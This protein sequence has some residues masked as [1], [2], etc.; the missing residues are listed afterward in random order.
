MEIPDRQAEIVA[1]E[2]DELSY[3][4]RLATLDRQLEALVELREATARAHR[5]AQNRLTTARAEG[6]KACPQSD[7]ALPLPLIDA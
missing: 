1:A 5:R 7:A 4:L 2:A 3:R 6:W